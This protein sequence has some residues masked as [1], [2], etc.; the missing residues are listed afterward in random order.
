MKR[1]APAAQPPRTQDKG[2]LH[3]RNRHR[4]RYDFPAL[5]R[6]SPGLAPFVAVN[7]H[8]DPSVDFADPAAVWALNRALMAHVYGVTTWE[9]PPGY[10]CPPIPGRADYLHHLADLL[11][12]D[13]GGRIPRGPGIRALDVGTGATCVYAVLGHLEYG[14]RFLGSDIDAAA[15]ASAARIL[16][17]AS[18]A[19]AIELR[20]Q[21]APP[22]ILEGL[23]KPLERFEVSL[24]NPPFH[25]SPAQARE[26]T[27][28]KWRNLGRGTE[29][30]P[31]MDGGGPRPRGARAPSPRGMGGPSPADTLVR[32]FGGQD[33]ELWCPGGEAAFL[34]RLIAESARMRDLCAWF[35]SL[36]SRSETLPGARHALGEAGAVE[37]RI[38]PMAQGQKKSRI[39]AWTHLDAEARQSRT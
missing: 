32:N 37:V 12:S 36:V 10:L 4:T 28:R 30:G 25:A 1:T 20:R 39:L 5:V 16:D 26:G 17:A 27:E 23:V 8:G 18:L 15:L 9:A 19:E 38:I 22:R 33:A 2:G 31:G 35:T 29:A 6:A 7:A 14:W 24:C 34:A 3:P 11:A 13:R 21:E